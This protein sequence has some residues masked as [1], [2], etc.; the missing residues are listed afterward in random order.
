MSASTRSNGYNWTLKLL[1]TVTCTACSTN[2]DSIRLVATT[3]TTIGGLDNIGGLTGKFSK[4]EA[5]GFEDAMTHYVL[6]IADYGPVTVSGTLDPSDTSQ[7]AL[8]NE[9]F[10]EAAS[11]TA[12]RPTARVWAAVDSVNKRTHRFKGKVSGGGIGSVAKNG[13]ASFELEITLDSIPQACT[14]A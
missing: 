10:H 13:K 3:C 4:T 9:I 7:K 1:T 14:T 5:N 12:A 2:A 8:F 6:G 11:A